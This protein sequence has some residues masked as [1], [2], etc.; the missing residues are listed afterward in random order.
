ML[1]GDHGGVVDLV[2]MEGVAVAV[3][4]FGS[5]VVLILVLIILIVEVVVEV[6][7]VVLVIA[8]DIFPTRLAS[9]ARL[10][11]RFPPFVIGTASASIRRTTR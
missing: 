2:A 3:T 6:V 8:V 9:F 4:V 11:R 10:R 1:L 5:V 7:V